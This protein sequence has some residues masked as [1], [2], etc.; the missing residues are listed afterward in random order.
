MTRLEFEELQLMLT[1]LPHF[2]SK[3]MVSHHIS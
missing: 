3:R 2:S 1:S